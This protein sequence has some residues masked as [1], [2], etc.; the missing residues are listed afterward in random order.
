MGRQHKEQER[1]G[2]RSQAIK[3]GMERTKNW[4]QHVERPSVSESAEE[5]LANP[6]SQ[7][8]IEALEWSKDCH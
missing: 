1:A 3:T 8:V 5:F 2:R 7:K 4:N 6:S